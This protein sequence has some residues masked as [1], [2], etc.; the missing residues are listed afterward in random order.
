MKTNEFKILYDTQIDRFSWV[1][2]DA[3]YSCDDF[4]LASDAIYDAYRVLGL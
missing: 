1:S 2:A 4:E 3:I